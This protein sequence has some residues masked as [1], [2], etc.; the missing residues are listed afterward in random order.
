MNEV[1]NQPVQL[2]MAKFDKLSAQIQVLIAPIKGLTVTDQGSHIMA[3]GVVKTLKDFLKI[4]ED[5]RVALKQPHMDAAKNVDIQS[6][7]VSK[8]LEDALEFVNKQIT[9]WNALERKRIEDEQR[10]IE[11]HRIAAE[12][13][14]RRQQEIIAAEAAKKAKEEAAALKKKQDAERKAFELAAK[15]KE[16]AMKVFGVDEAKHA[17]EIAAAKKEI[18]DKLEAEKRAMKQKAEEARLETEARLQREQAERQAAFKAQERKLEAERPKGMREVPDWQ[19]GNPDLVPE[20]YWM[21]NETK[22][23]MDVRAK[24]IIP[25]ITVTIRMVPVSR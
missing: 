13:E 11:E 4:T 5:T 10:K 15:A 24:K 22:I 25:G 9:D 7:T 18:T 3:K 16:E 21:L 12:R 2:E 17:E 6:K 19:L 23:G 20:E 1:S 8:P 14:A